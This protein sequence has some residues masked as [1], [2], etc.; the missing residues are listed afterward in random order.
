MDKLTGEGKLAE[1]VY[2][3]PNVEVI[4]STIVSGYL[5]NSEFEGVKILS[6]DGTEREIKLD[7][8][9]VAIGLIPQNKAFSN[10]IDLNTYG[11]ASSGEDCLTKTK[12]VFV[13]GD[14]RSKKIRQVA[15]AMADGA[16]SALAACDYIDGNGG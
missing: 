4:F 10:V 3:K 5:G 15:T 14:C 9:F 8:L 7:G 11:Y 6:S 16:I 2:S 13:A 1:Q 12:G